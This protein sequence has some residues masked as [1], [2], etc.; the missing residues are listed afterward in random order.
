MQI[1]YKGDVILKVKNDNFEILKEYGFIQSKVANYPMKLVKVVDVDK[2]YVIEVCNDPE[3]SYNMWSGKEWKGV[4][5]L[6][7]WECDVLDLE[8]KWSDGE[9]SPYYETRRTHNT[10]LS[11]YIDDLINDGIVEN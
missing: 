6:N 7:L 5:V 4:G 11:S 10:L 2:K 1:K 9:I 8:Y 3:R